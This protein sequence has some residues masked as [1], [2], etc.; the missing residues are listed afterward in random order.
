MNP[1]VVAALMLLSAGADG[2]EKLWGTWRLVAF[3]RVDAAGHSTDVFGKD[4]R[5]YITYGSDG[6]MS[7]VIVKPGRPRSEDASKTTDAERVELFKT[8]IAYA[9][10]Y[11]FDGENVVHHIDVSANEAWTGT[12]QIRHVKFDGRRLILTTDPTASAFDGKVD[13]RVLTFEKLGGTVP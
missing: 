7:V 4:P 11:T 9:G 12:D 3:T 8:L 10:A 1:A 5:G 6:R 2:P 13:V